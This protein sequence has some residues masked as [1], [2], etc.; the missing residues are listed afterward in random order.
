[1][2]ETVSTASSD[3]YLSRNEIRIVVLSSVGSIFEWFDFFLY[4]WLAV[5]LS[6]QFFSK[7]GYPTRLDVGVWH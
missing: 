1:M 3:A 6:H 4:G 2:H 7:V 5:I